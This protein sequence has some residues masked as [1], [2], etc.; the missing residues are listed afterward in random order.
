V[1]K[2]EI[3]RGN[4]DDDDPD[5]VY[6]IPSQRDEDSGP[7]KEGL[8]VVGIGIAI[9]LTVAFLT[10]ELGVMGGVW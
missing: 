8:V 5:A 2:H 10:Y 9:L 3:Q 4:H 7:D 1:G 6:E